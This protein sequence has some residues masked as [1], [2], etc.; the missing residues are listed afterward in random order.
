MKVGDALW[1]ETRADHR[2]VGEVVARVSFQR[3]LRTLA[4]QKNFKVTGQPFR[5]CRAFSKHPVPPKW[6]SSVVVELPAA[7]VGAGRASAHASRQGVTGLPG[8]LRIGADHIEVASEGEWRLTLALALN[9]M[10]SGSS[11]VVRDASGRDWYIAPASQAAAHSLREA[12]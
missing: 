3:R 9:Q 11:L 12:A 7:S 2:A 10:A 5:P 8:A 4:A 1:D 6:G